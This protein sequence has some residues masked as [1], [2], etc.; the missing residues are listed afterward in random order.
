VFVLDDTVLVIEYEWNTMAFGRS[1]LASARRIHA[2]QHASLGYKKS[3]D[4]FKRDA[5]DCILVSEIPPI[6]TEPDSSYETDDCE[7]DD[8]LDEIPF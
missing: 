1:M 4:D 8:D 3:V 7:L 2:E 5:P 6:A